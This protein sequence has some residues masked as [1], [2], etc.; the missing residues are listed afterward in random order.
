M[1]PDGTSVSASCRTFSGDSPDGN[2]GAYIDQGFE[3]IS[4]EG[5]NEFTTPRI[6][7]SKVN[8]LTRLENYPGRKSFAI[9]IT[10]NTEDQF[11]APQIDLDRVSAILVM[12]RL[13]SKV[14]NYATDRRVNSIDNDPNAAI[15][16]TEVINLDKAADG[17]KVMFDAYRHQ[18]NDIRVLYRSF[19]VDAPQGDQLFQLF[20]GYNNLDLAGGIIDS[21]KSDGLPDKFVPPS[22]GYE[23]FNPYE[24]NIANIPQ[25]SAF[26]IKICMSGTNFAYVPRLKDLRVIAT[27]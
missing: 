27:I 9:E 7:A 22:D 2:L 6:I 12:N 18:T 17:L 16:L 13:N 11:V 1:Q 15:Y 26:Q 23:D 24:F 20:P 14:T 21:T 19:R 5:D 8:E 10:L 4:L 3:T 25:F